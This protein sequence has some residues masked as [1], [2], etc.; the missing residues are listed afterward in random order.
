MYEL[1]TFG[2]VIQTG[3]HGSDTWVQAERDET[4]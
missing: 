3:T 1:E 4:A 2:I